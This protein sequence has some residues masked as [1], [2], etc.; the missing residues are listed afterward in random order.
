[1]SISAYRYNEFSERSEEDYSPVPA[2]TSLFDET[3]RQWS[4]EFRLLSATEDSHDYVTGIFLSSRETETER[5]AN[6]IANS[7][8]DLASVVTPGMLDA[9]TAALFVNSNW[10][11]A[12]GMELTALP[13]AI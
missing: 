13:P 9:S 8:G 10:R 2:I 11:F 6:Q 4:Q 1:M 5:R 3:S 7:A 12:E